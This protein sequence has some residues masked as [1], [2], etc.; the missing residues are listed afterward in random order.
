MKK[1]SLILSLIALTSTASAQFVVS[2]QLGGSYAFGSTTP[3][4][5]FTGHSLFTGADTTYV[6]PSDT[7]THDNPLYLTIG[8]KFGYQV[9][10]LQVGIA[11]SFAW[12]HDRCDMSYSQFN[13]NHIMPDHLNPMTPGG[14][15]YDAPYVDYEGWYKQRR[16]QFT[17]APYVRYELIQLG[18]VAF[19][20]ELNA[21]Y[22]RVFQPVRHDYADW[23][24]FEMHNTIDTAYHILDSAR[25][26]GAKIIP[27]L[28]WQLSPHCYIDLY[29]DVLAFTFDRTTHINTDVLDEY[30]FTSGTPTLASRTTTTV[31]TKTTDIGFGVNGSN[32][33]SPTGRNW[34][35]IGFNY[36]F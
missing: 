31:T 6:V 26:L 33:L 13:L 22:S 8:G 14:V 10:R 34:V 24:R 29:L 12:T 27:G 16:S 28:S 36:T 18:D 20:L 5:T 1:I 35:R 21:Y 17:I 23:Y 4:A 19:F 11:A 9:G 2:A 3:D 32:L 30:I 15:I 7:L 25:S